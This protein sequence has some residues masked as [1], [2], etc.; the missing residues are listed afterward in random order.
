M[1]YNFQEKRKESIFYISGTYLL[2]TIKSI[3]IENEAGDLNK[4]IF[5]LGVLNVFLFY[6]LP[7][8]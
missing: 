8:I 6:V 3:R 1:L 5:V 7:E 4:R 2:A